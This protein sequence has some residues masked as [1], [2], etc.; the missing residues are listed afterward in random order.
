[1]ATFEIREDLQLRTRLELER[2]IAKNNAGETL[3]SGE[4]AMLTMKTC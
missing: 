2:V 4:T 1:M 3:T